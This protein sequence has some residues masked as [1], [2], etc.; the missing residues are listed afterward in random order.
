M[1]RCVNLK[2]AY[3]QQLSHY[4]CKQCANRKGDTYQFEPG[5]EG[6]ADDVST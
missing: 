3:G 1:Y 6:A 5:M 2:A 4:I